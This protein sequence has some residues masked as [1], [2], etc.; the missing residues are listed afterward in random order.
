MSPRHGSVDFSEW[1]AVRGQRGIWIYTLYI[2][3]IYI[4]HKSQTAC[5]VQCAR[6]YKA[7]LVGSR[8]LRPK[9]RT[10]KSK[11]GG[12]LCSPLL[13]PFLSI[14]FCSSSFLSLSL[15]IFFVLLLLISLACFASSITPI[16]AL[17][18]TCL[19]FTMVSE[20]LF[21][22]SWWSN[23]HWRLMQMDEAEKGWSF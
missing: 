17:A 4:S 2:I 15:S 10:E 3:Y 14:F 6:G 22:R 1:D 16:R 11:S 13:P 7:A 21:F 5:N 12:P 23:N 20:S 19:M 9:I 18:Y 8:V